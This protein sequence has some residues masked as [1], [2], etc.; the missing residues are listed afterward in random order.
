M[1]FGFTVFAACLASGV[2]GTSVSDMDGIVDATT[3]DMV[4]LND[5]IQAEKQNEYNIEA[6]YADMQK[7]LSALKEEHTRSETERVSMRRSLNEAR[8]H[9]ATLSR[10]NQRLTGLVTAV[11]HEQAKLSQAKEEVIKALDLE[12][13]D[14]D[15]NSTQ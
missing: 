10:Q 5:L 3:Q 1:R 4:K 8:T 13:I 12:G 15:V 6:L 9:V 11:K 7:R 14:L 2:A